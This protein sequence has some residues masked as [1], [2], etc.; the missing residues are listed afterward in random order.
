MSA[1]PCASACLLGILGFTGLLA[2]TGCSSSSLSSG[3]TTTPPPTAANVAPMVITVSDAPLSNIL[4]AKVT[5]SALALT[6]SGGGTSVSVLSQPETVEL[7]GLGAVQEPLEIANLAFGTY[8]SV[9]VTVSAAEVTYLDSTGNAVTA[10]ATVSGAAVTVALNPPLTVSSDGEL[11]LRVAFNLAQSFSIT[12]TTVTFTP[13]L[14]T[15]A[16]NVSS[17]S[18]GDRKLE[19][20]GSVVSVSP[21]SITVQSADSGK[22][23]QFAIQSSTQLPNG[24]SANSIQT[25]AIVEVLGQ[26]QS[27]GTLLAQMITVEGGQSEHEHDGAK[28]IITGVTQDGAGTVTAFTMAPREDFGATDGHGSLNVALSSSTTLGVSEDAQQAG[29]TTSLFTLAEIFPGQ[30]VT[31]TG[32]VDSTGTLNAQ[33]IILAA[34]SV[35]GTLASTPQGSNPDYTFTL[36]VPTP[37]FLTIFGKIVSLNTTTSQNTEYG[38]G[39]TAASFSSLAAA[40][41]L[42]VHGFLL[43]DPHGSY[44]LYATGIAQSETPEQPESGN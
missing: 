28:G 42:E 40:T 31:V 23:F 1:K 22:Q 14:N 16:A 15:A 43:V 10:N 18:D 35:P 17:E 2:L 41:S 21:T 27:D 37:S 39:L 44:T 38:G 20:T 7:S 30:S 34:E 36:T 5:I 25:G 32:A 11:H 6:P 26:T 29:I 13:A 12:G 3:S 24:V 8:N 33:Q 4:S 19:V 9:S